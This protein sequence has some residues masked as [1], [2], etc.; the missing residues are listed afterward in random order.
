MHPLIGKTIL[1]SQY[2]STRTKKI[3]KTQTIPADSKKRL[4]RIIAEIRSGIKPHRQD[5][6]FT[7]SNGVLHCC[8]GGWLCV[9]EFLATGEIL[10]DWVFI[11]KDLVTS[12]KLDSFIPGRL[13]RYV[14]NSLDIDYDWCW[15]NLLAADLTLDQIEENINS[16]EVIDYGET[17]TLVEKRNRLEKKLAKIKSQIQHERLGSIENLKAGDKFEYR[18]KYHI[19]TYV[20]TCLDAGSFVLTEIKTGSIWTHPGTLEEIRQEL[21]QNDHFYRIW[22]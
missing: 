15:E 11:G 12:A 1:G 18:G 14:A 8:I 9:D 22:N 19:G 21:L 13:S 2:C 6:Y 10:D 17:E 5:L 7:V 3:M 4:L 16:L 20:L